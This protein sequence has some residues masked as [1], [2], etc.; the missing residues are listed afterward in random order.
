MERACDHTRLKKSE[1][2]ARGNHD[3]TWRVGP[4]WFFEQVPSHM[5]GDHRCLLSIYRCALGLAFKNF[6][7]FGEI[8]PRGVIVDGVLLAHGNIAHRFAA[9]HRAPVWAHGPRVSGPFSP[10][11][12]TCLLYLLILIFLYF[13]NIKPLP[14]EKRSL[15]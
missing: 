5:G 6:A 11:F 10:S 4:P 3:V 7:S 8:V 9:R 14:N 15:R 1:E 13:F 2:L 12:V